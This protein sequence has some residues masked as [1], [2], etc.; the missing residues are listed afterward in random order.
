MPELL[1]LNHTSR[2][3]GIG[4]GSGYQTAILAELAA[5]VYTIEINPAHHPQQPRHHTRT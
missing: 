3:F 4:T 1:E 2:V 5:T